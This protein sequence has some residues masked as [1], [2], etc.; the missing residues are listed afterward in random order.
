M[1]QSQQQTQA[2]GI[3]EEEIRMSIKLSYVEGTTE[4]LRH[5]IKPQKIRST[6]Y[7]KSILRELLCKLKDRVATEDKNKIVYEMNC[8]NWEA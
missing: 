7:T 2:R 4:K 8:S 3:Q 6:F 1:S 5:I